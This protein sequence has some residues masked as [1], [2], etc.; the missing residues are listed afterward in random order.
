MVDKYASPEDLHAQADDGGDGRRK[1]KA[2][3][4]ATHGVA[5]AM[6]G[7]VIAAV[8]GKIRKTKR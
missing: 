5:N 2:E 1:R 3:A 7:E 6:A 8:S 4:Q